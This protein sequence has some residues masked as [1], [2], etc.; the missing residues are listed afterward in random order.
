[1]KL[2]F[3][4]IAA[5]RQSVKFLTVGARSDRGILAR[6]LDRRVPSAATQGTVAT[7]LHALG[8]MPESF[9]DYLVATFMQMGADQ[10]G[11]GF[12]WDIY[13]H[14]SVW[15]TARSL[16]G[17][18]IVAPEQ[19]LNDDGTS[20]RLLGA[21]EW[22]EAQRNADGGFGFQNGLES[23]VVYSAFVGQA[24]LAG[25]TAASAVPALSGVIELLTAR[26]KSLLHYLASCRLG[27]QHQWSDGPTGKVC[28]MSTLFALQLARQASAQVSSP[29][30]LRSADAVKTA[31]AIR[32]QLREAG[33]FYRFRDETAVNW[34]FE[35]FV[36]G[37]LR[38]L[39]ELFEVTDDLVQKNLTY[40]SSAI[41]MRDGYCGWGYPDSREPVTWVTALG[42]DSIGWA[43]ESY[44]ALTVDGGPAFLS[45]KG[46]SMTGSRKVFVVHGHDDGAREA[47]ARVLEKLG[48]EAVI[49]HEQV[50]CGRTVIEKFEAHSDVSFAVVILTPDDEGGKRKGPMTGRARQNVVLELGYFMGKLGRS[51]VLALK[52]GD[53]EIPTDF[54]GVI[55]IDLDA[56][57]AWRHR[58]GKELINAGLPADLSKL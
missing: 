24:L 34:R 52:R 58:I 57:G 35:E 18:L 27:G 36:P 37:R 6:T 11:G 50:D 13:E 33:P 12:A 51:R 46:G 9:R 17:L 56:A 1:V 7:A 23:R 22:L 10:P 54:S 2:V 19:L 15:A 28:A 55:Y 42:L 16:Q 49:L 47:V 43:I 45:A 53:V 3:E 4:E 21:F 14:S 31:A 30:T 32:K 41:V 25:I 44:A 26:L 29:I 48:L 38:L 40:L 8:I 20:Q 5:L 39:G